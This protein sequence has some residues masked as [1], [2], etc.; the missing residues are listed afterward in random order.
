MPKV[1]DTLTERDNRYGSM[2]QNAL[3]TQALMQE[4]LYAA[5][6]NGSSLSPMHVECLHMIMHKVAR[7]VIGDQWYA[8]NPHDIAGYATRLEDY[9]RDMGEEAL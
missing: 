5:Y 6:E 4:I 9:I 3:L 1:D 2:V 7:M 8:D